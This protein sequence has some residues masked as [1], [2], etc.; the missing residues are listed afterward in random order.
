[1]M[2]KHILNSWPIDGVLLCF[3]ISGDLMVP[4]VNQSLSLTLARGLRQP[5][6]F[7]GK[8]IL[9]WCIQA[10]MYTTIQRE[11]KEISNPKRRSRWCLWHPGL[12]SACRVVGL[13]RSGGMGQFHCL[14]QQGVLQPFAGYEMSCW[15]GLAEPS[16]A[17]CNCAGTVPV[18]CDVR[19]D[20][21]RRGRLL[22]FS[23]TCH[24]PND[25]A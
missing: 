17:R 12:F 20:I 15:T 24:R 22:L 23:S 4:W 5:T 6:L 7:K 18:A 25:L 3:R 8:V 1:M 21:A 11:S 9:G 2:I 16:W 14:G 10:V 13:E 19:G